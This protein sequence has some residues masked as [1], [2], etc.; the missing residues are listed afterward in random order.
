MAAVPGPGTSEDLLNLSAS[1][2]T[3]VSVPA[4][5]GLQLDR[6]RSEEQQADTLAREASEG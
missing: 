1:K 4:L 6:K 3:V 5:E 2:H